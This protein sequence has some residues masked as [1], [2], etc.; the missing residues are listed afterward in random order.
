[1]WRLIILTIIFCVSSLFAV[2]QPPSIIY[3][4]IFGISEHNNQAEPIIITA[5]LNDKEIARTFAFFDSENEQSHNYLLRINHDSGMD[6]RNIFGI[7]DNSA[8]RL[9]ANCN[10]MDFL[11]NEALVI[12]EANSFIQQDFV[13]L[14]EPCVLVG[15]A[16]M[17]WLFRR[18]KL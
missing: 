10:S 12:P 9:N 16:A 4:K 15:F 11:V 2:P 6:L 8:I 14:P 17:L 1:M 5:Y 13:L 18:R 3:G 7:K